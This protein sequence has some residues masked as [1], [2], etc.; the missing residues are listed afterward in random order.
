MIWHFIDFMRLSGVYY[1]GMIFKKEII[2]RGTLST[3]QGGDV[4]VKYI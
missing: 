3:C 4:I 1:R 2:A